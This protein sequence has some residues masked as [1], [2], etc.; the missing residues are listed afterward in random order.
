[1]EDLTD[2][3]PKLSSPAHSSRAASEGKQRLD[4]LEQCLNQLENKERELILEY[5]QGEKRTKI[6]RRAHLATSLGLS[7]NALSIRACRIRN[8]LEDCVR[9]CCDKTET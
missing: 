6:E 9:K 2:N 7:L 8:K 5:Y 1:L 3:H 4:C